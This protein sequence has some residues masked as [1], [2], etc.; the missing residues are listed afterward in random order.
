MVYYLDLLKPADLPTYL[1]TS[2]CQGT[3]SSGLE[4]STLVIYLFFAQ[5]T[6][7]ETIIFSDA[8]IPVVCVCVRCA[9]VRVRE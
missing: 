8:C 4:L 6:S 5:T 3:V 1:L 9:G 2:S 7:D